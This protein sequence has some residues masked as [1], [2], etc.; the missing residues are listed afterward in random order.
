[1]RY[2][3][4]YEVVFT[5][6]ELRHHDLSDIGRGV[7]S[8]L[9]IRGPAQEMV[10]ER[11]AAMHRI[12]LAFL[13]HALGGKPAA[14]LSEAMANGGGK[15]TLAVLPATVPAP[16]VGTLV[17][18]FTSH[19]S[20]ETLATLR[21]AQAG[22][23]EA[24]IFVAGSLVE[25]AQRLTRSGRSAAA[26]ELLRFALELHPQSKEVAEALATTRDEMAHQ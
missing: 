9:K 5:D 2:S 16:S 21:S 24:P 20:Q 15:Y 14:A 6:P 23:P 12:V 13:D 7:S 8:V 18:G 17:D 4:R 10:L 3:E 11:Y 22:D 1:M 19:G 26:L 25:A